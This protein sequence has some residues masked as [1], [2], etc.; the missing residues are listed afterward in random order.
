MAQNPFDQA[1]RYAAKLDPFGLLVW[2]YRDHTLFDFLGWLDA[3]TVP[4]PHD[5]GLTGPMTVRSA[6][7]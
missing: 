4:F 3:R 5:P 7:R 6:R 2:L 1:S